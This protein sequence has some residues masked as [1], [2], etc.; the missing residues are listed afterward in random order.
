[1]TQRVSNASLFPSRQSTPS[2]PVSWW[3]ETYE[4]T[5]TELRACTK[6]ARALRDGDATKHGNT[7]TEGPGAVIDQ[8]LPDTPWRRRAR[9]YEVALEIQDDLERRAG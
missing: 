1:M 6:A 8:A 3:I 7:K 2:M 9:L 5:E 4:V